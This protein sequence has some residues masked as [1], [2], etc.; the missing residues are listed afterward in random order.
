VTAP[1]SLPRRP[2]EVKWIEARPVRR[3]SGRVAVPGDKSISHRSILLSALA[4]GESEVRGFLASEDCLAS[5]KAMRALGVR[6]EQPEPARVRVRGVGLHGLKAAAHA[7][8]MGNA[9]TAMRLFAGLLAAQSFASTLIGDA[10]LMQRPME[11][12]ARPLRAMGADVR[13][14][15]GKPPLEIGGGRRL[16]GIEYHM[17]VASAQVKSALLLAALY[18]DGPTTVSSP[19]ACRDHSERM[20]ASA[21]VR[22][23]TSGLVTTLHPP[24]R[25]ESQSLEVPGDFSSAA[26]F[27]VAGL[28]GAAPEGMLLENV[29]LNPTRTGLLDILR[30]MGGRIEV[31]NL[32]SSGA[33]PVADLRVHS[34]ALL[35]IDVPPAAVPLAIDEF[36]VLFIAA[37][38]ARGQTRVTGAEELRV[39]E[40]DRIAAMAAGFEAM[41]VAHEA[42]ADGMLIEGK[43]DGAA[44]RGGEIDSR[45]DHRIAMAFSVASLRAAQPIAVRDTANVATSFPGF[46]ALARAVGLDLAESSVSRA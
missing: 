26:F 35:G 8:D 4:S 10:S 42:T 31:E 19:A 39:K 6:I 33:E 27:I 34:S 40:S 7:L 22:I 28:L 3:V 1:A 2:G 5:L 36:P 43:P 23:D 16:H 13:T 15:D 12:V 37:A 32:R 11:R 38:C 29:G 41:G 9:G 18:A 17:P 46:V 24:A 25:L 30:S 44:F 45:G 21:G 14:H 20:L